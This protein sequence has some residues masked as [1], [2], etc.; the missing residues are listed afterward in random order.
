MHERVYYGRYNGR[1]YGRAYLHGKRSFFIMVLFF[2]FRK[3][4]IKIPNF[5]LFFLS[6]SLFLSVTFLP[7]SPLPPP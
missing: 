6:V 4:Q 3:P 5:F 1:G 2:H 7:L